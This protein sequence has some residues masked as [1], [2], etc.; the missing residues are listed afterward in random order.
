[1]ILARDN[2]KFVCWNSLTS[3]DTDR[4][5]VTLQLANPGHA[6]SESAGRPLVFRI[7]SSRTL[8]HR[9]SSLE[10]VAPHRRLS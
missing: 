9:G 7:E 4:S 10:A 6:G 8:V 1:M 5:E 3:I 2:R